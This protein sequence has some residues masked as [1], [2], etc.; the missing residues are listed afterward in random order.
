VRELGL[1]ARVEFRGFVD[2]GSVT[3]LL[4]GFDAVVVPSLWPEPWARVIQE[5]MAVGAA[6]VASRVGGTPS[7]IADGESG[8]LYEAGD[9][10]GLA[11]RMERL[12]RD[13]PLR[14]RLGE[15]AARVA[16]ERFDVAA[17]VDRIEQLLAALARQAS[18]G[19]GK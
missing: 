5:A 2:R 15:R 10:R 8:L 7:L 13:P 6:V 19:Q 12:I 16:G 9:A 18:G 14:V 3:E 17:T 1:E 4:R 11:D